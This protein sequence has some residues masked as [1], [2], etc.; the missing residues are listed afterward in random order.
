VKSDGGDTEYKGPFLREVVAVAR[1]AAE[2]NTIRLSALDGYAVEL[3]LSDVDAQRWV[4]AMEANG[5]AFGIGDFGPLY[6]VRQLW[7]DETKAEEE[8]A[9]WVFSIYY[10]EL[11]G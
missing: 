3:A 6:L 5:N 9:K 11:M 10:I 2:A 7:P 8:G 1:P 4:L